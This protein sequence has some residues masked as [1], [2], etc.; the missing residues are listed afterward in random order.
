MKDFLDITFD[1]A[2]CRREVLALQ[3][4]LGANTSL[5]ENKDIKPF[6]E[7]NRHLSACSGFYGWEFVQPD[8]LSYQYQ[9]FGDFA[10][11]LAVGDSARRTFGFIELEDATP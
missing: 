9:L 6:F 7:A 4:L 1:P 5:E 8:Q 10:C 2:V 3:S 11:D